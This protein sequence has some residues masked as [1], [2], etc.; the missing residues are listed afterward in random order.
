MASRKDRDYEPLHIRAYLRS[1]V[2]SDSFLPFDAIIMYQ[3]HRE[4]E[5]AQVASL[6]GAYST[7]G[8]VSLPFANVSYGSN[9]D[10]LTGNFRRWD[11]YTKCSWA[12]WPEHVTEARDYWN[13]RFDNGLSDWINFGN[14]QAQVIIDKGAYKAYHQAIFYRAALW[15]EWYCIGDKA[16]IETLLSTLTHIGKKTGQGWGRVSRW[17]VRSI[18]DDYSVWMG[19][20]LMRG[21]P[22]DQAPG[23]RTGVYG[24]RPSYW[25]K[26]NQ[27]LLAL[28]EVV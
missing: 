14:R 22:P 8:G 28:P 7:Q 20:R 5:G 26:Q 4:R 11:Q 17:E 1:G 6:P 23:W 15:V 16:R 24:I 3:A 21:V 25:N 27:M 18:S 12:Q 2:V 19:D 13:K 9:P 10:P